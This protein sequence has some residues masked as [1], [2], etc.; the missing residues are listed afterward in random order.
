MRSVVSTSDVYST[1]GNPRNSLPVLLRT[2]RS[3]SPE[4]TVSPSPS[5]RTTA[6]RTSPPA[7]ENAWSWGPPEVVAIR[8]QAYRSTCWRAP[9]TCSWRSV[10]HRAIRSANSSGVDTPPVRASA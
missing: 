6:V 2:T 8:S 7:R 5:L 4:I 10:N 9:V 1:S 3:R